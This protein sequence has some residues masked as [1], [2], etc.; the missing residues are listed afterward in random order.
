VFG[1]LNVGVQI[2][3]IVQ[4]G[5]MFVMLDDG[6]VPG[7]GEPSQ[8]ART[9]AEIQSRFFRSQQPSRDV[10]RYAHLPSKDQAQSRHSDFAFV[11]T[12]DSVPLGEAKEAA[13]DYQSCAFHRKRAKFREQGQDHLLALFASNGVTGVGYASHH[14]PIKT[15]HGP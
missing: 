8:L 3:K 1:F 15:E 9:H 5:R 14:S 11:Q 2:L 7:L 4:P 10:T 12:V 6:Q 13:A